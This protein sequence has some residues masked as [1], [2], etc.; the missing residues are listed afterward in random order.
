[1][2]RK[3]KTV[4]LAENLI[5]SLKNSDATKKYYVALR[6]EELISI[7]YVKE[8]YLYNT[9][10]NMVVDHSKIYEYG[11]KVGD[12]MSLEE[13]LNDVI[14]MILKNS[15][16]VNQYTERILFLTCNNKKEVTEK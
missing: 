4:I 1:M 14:C 16:M 10:Y 6:M 9:I 12:E 3:S 15:I 8:R 5:E 11:V 7:T 2:A 13:Y